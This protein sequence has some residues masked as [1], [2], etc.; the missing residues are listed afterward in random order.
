[1]SVVLDITTLRSFTSIADYGGFRHAAEALDL[2]QSAI[3]Q[4]VRRLERTVGRALVERHGRGSRFTADGELLLGRA[5][6][7][8]AVH[9]DAVTHLRITA[10]PEGKTTFTIGAPE[11]A[12]DVIL[13]RINTTL[14]D[15]YPGCSVYFRIDR[16]A[17]LREYLED[18]TVDVALFLGELGAGH[19]LPAGD[20]P[21]AW[22]ASP[23]WQRLSGVV[24]LVSIDKP[25]TLRHRAL[26]T[27][28]HHDL[29]ADVVCETGH[30]AGVLHATRAGLGVALLAQLGQPPEGLEQRLDLPPVEPESL[31]VRAS[32][33]SRPG[34]ALVVADAAREALNSYYLNNS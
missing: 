22:Y 5:R 1:M 23:T 2:S 26:S 18:G 21:L 7:I 32:I 34:V 30:L 11:H 31:H 10:E 24:P 4:H 12:A 13:P 20:L 14:R 25:C 15:Q 33:M 16:A 6:A 8:L 19:F 28:A 27:L 3:S 9:D 17:R 29:P